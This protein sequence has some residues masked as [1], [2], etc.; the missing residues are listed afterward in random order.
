VRVD[1]EAIRE[2]LGNCEGGPA[3]ENIEARRDRIVA[4]MWEAY[5]SYISSGRRGNIEQDADIEEVEV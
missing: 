5:Q 2:Q 3:I 4:E 1:L